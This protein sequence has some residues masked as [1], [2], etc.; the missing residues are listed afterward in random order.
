[1]NSSPP[2]L[3]LWQF[4]SFHHEGR[5]APSCWCVSAPRT[6]PHKPAALI[7]PP[8][9]DRCFMLVSCGNHASHPSLER[10][11]VPGSSEVTL[12]PLPAG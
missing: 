8:T 7:G 10:C 1:M 6:E 3:D 9:T 12:F 11:V 4:Q 2:C 5:V